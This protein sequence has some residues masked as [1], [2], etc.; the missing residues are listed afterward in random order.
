MRFIEETNFDPL[1]LRRMRWIASLWTVALLACAAGAWWDAR[2]AAPA[3]VQA[4]AAAPVAPS[5]SPA[6]SALPTIAA[7][8]TPTTIPG[9]SHVRRQ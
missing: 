1:Q 3:T 5:A 9:D 7:R 6:T 4:A 8:T 2:L